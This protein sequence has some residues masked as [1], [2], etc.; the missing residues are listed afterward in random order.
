MTGSKIQSF[1]LFKAAMGNPE[2]LTKIN[3]DTGSQAQ[4]LTTLEE[5]NL[6]LLNILESIQIVQ[7]SKV[8]S[9]LII[10]LLSQKEF[11]SSLKGDS[12]LNRLTLQDVHIPS[13]LNY[14]IH[15]LDLKTLSTQLIGKL[16]PEAAVSV[17]CS[18]PH[19]HQ[20]TK[21]Q[22]EALFERYP[23]YE[24]H[25]VLTY[26]INHFI[27]MP[28]AHYIL[29]HLMN[30][31]GHNIIDELSKMEPNQKEIVIL[32]IIEHLGLF[33]NIPIKF[34]DHAN[35]ESHLILAM[36]FYLNGHYNKAYASFIN[37]LSKRLLDK[38]HS[39]SLEAIEL[40]FF[41]NDKL[42]FKELAKR[43]AHLTNRYLRNNALKG[44]VE[45]F[46]QNNRINIQRM[47][48]NVH[49]NPLFAGGEAREQRPSADPDENPFIEGL[50]KHDKLINCFEYFLIHYK[51]NSE[52]IG[53]LINDY[54]QFYAQSE[55]LATRAKAIHHIGFMLGR[56][57]LDGTVKEALF[58][59]FL[60]H[61]DFFDEQ[62]SYQLFL[63]DAKRII[64]YFGL[65]GGKE[66]YQRVI[67][68]CTLALKN[69][70]SEK[71]QEIILIAQK[72]LSEAQHELRF[73]KEQGFF[74]GLIKWIKRCWIYGWTGF[75]K[76][77]SPD[78]VV[79]ESLGLREK[80]KKPSNWVKKSISTRE[81]EK[82]LPDLLN[83][84]SLPL[85]Q[86]QFED[87]IKALDSYSL[88]AMP[89]DELSTRQKLHR[90]YH[91]VMNRKE[92][93]EGL[94]RWLK[95]N[96]NPFITNQFRLLELMLKERPRGD[97][98][99]LLAQVNEDSDHLHYVFNELD[100]L[101]PELV[102][103]PST[104]PLKNPQSSDFV[105]SATKV[106]S[107][108]TCEAAVYAQSAFHWAEGFFAK[109]KN[110]VK[111]EEPF[112]VEHIDSFEKT[113]SG[114]GVPTT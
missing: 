112:E 13:R 5:G 34:L 36:R 114:K 60:N 90:L 108:Y 85:T 23:L 4:F 102:I 64:R 43:T 113:I 50:I 14:L 46:Y 44:N 99:S 12:L 110:P 26:W 86:E 2:Y 49:L 96:Q 66:N 81:T 22:I 63:F 71:N 6:T 54:M 24:R 111:E 45:L 74:S 19:F 18:V 38:N 59:A 77:N 53:K 103:K 68:L 105:A 72:A 89:K 78:Y 33:N 21:T 88:Q 8:K 98:D 37:Q 20:L 87:I 94:Y 109:I 11:L 106:L 95:D 28:N 16:E 83:A 35:K 61:P 30:I 47:L 10:Y 101:L 3:K 91:Y 15:Q 51:G 1:D 75:F 56:H 39:F 93:N 79:P 69:L 104:K 42:A 32:N 29:A 67:D 17:L 25:K 92:E 84:V 58:T 76:P 48:Q 27:S 7:N 70:N 55:N 73:A 65:R 97:V 57:E 80:N 62:V 9:L 107:E 82:D 31:A 52:S 40:L 41:L 100:C